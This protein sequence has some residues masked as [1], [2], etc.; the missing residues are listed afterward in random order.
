MALQGRAT[1][2]NTITPYHHGAQK[3]VMPNAFEGSLKSGAPIK[4]MLGQHHG[5]CIGTTWDALDLFSD[6]DGLAFRFRFPET[7]IGNEAR[8]IAATNQNSEMSI[9]FDYA[10]AQKETRV[11]DGLPVTVICRAWLYE[12]TWLHGFN[13]SAVKS[14]FAA[15]VNID[16]STLQ[17]D[18]QGLKLQSDG[19]AVEVNRAFQKLQN[20]LQFS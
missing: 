8:A 17:Q 11:I 3:L 12:I 1:R 10:G 2:Y 13:I 20:A 19:R 7:V 18:C 9:G 15:Y 16:H 6:L 14:A 4:F 5:P